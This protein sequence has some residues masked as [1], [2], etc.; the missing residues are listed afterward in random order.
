VPACIPNCTQKQCGPDGCGGVCG[1]CS[2][3]NACD[4]VGRCEPLP[5]STPISFAH[6]IQPILDARCTGCHSGGQLDF[7]FTAGVAYGKLV[8]VRSKSCPGRILVVPGD[9]THS[10]VMDKV[11]P[12]MG[13]CAG[14]SMRYGTTDAELRTLGEW[15]NQGAPNN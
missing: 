6:D 2:S 1:V 7:D 4:A 5:Q 11:Q 13:I 12:A 3:G 9:A 8:N 14:S 15:I 10:Y